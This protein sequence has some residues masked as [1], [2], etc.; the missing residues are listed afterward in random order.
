[1]GRPRSGRR[2][3]GRVVAALAVLAMAACSGT[4][5]DVSSDAAGE[6][7]T[8]GSDSAPSP[9][10]TAVRTT[11]SVTVPV[12][13]T[14]CGGQAADP[15]SASMTS[16]S[17]DVDGDGRLDAVRVYR[18]AGG[19]WRVRIEFAAGGSSELKLEGQGL[20][21]GGAGA[22]RSGD[23]DGDGL[24]EVFVRIGGGDGTTQV[25]F[26]SVNNC[27]IEPVLFSGAPVVFAVGVAG[28]AINGV[29]CGPAADRARRVLYVSEGQSGDGGGFNVSTSG[30]RLDAGEL[31]LVG[32]PVLSD[33]S[34]GDEGYVAASTFSCGEGV[35]A[36]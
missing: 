29:Q 25:A 13:S 32:E 1:M 14:G 33:V 31:T 35:I 9:A 20:E 34:F 28:S 27:T 17:A 3:A 24:D 22:L 36:G 30:Y 18:T 16:E 21:V 23:I 11:T 4:D 19:E 5:D 7:T 12:E 26:F 6:T 15:D 8:V 2:L 10:T